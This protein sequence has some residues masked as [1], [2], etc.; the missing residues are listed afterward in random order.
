MGCYYQ[1]LKA[2]TTFHYTYKAQIYTNH[3]ISASEVMNACHAKDDHTP[4]L[5]QD[6]LVDLCLFFSMQ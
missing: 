1:R 4:Q 3:V 2:L 5:A 6:H